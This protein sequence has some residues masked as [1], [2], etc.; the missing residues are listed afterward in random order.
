VVKHALF[1]L[2]LLAAL[3]A[4]APAAPAAAQSAER[5][6]PETGQ[7]IAGPIRAY[8]ERNGGLERFG[9]P[10][11]PQ[12]VETVEG[13]TIQVQW[14]ERDR[15]EIQADGL[16]TAGR[17]GVQRLEQLGIQWQQLP[18][19]NAIIPGCRFFRETQLNVCG[20]FLAY[21]E[22]NGGLER[23]GY[24][25]TRERT[26][27]LEGREY[28]VQYFERRRME[29]HPENAGTPYAVLLGLLGREVLG[30]GQGAAIPP[31][32]ENINPNLRAVYARV[33]L[34]RPLGCPTLV[35]GENVPAAIQTMERG[36]MIWY[37]RAEGPP[38][39]VLGPRIF[40][41]IAPNNTLSFR[42]Y[43][44]TWVEG[45]DPDVPAGSPPRPDLFAPWRGF[46]KVWAADADLRAQ[47]GWAR[48]S[49][50][51]ADRADY[52]LFDSG[53]LLVHLREA[54]ITYAFG[55]PGS[56]SEVQAFVR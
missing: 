40:A 27:V 11:T 47:I 12:R 50:A 23:F 39:L 51:R 48:E 21:W 44:D 4:L 33:Q 31:C 38:M 14:F 15:L 34:G 55:S 7:C 42:T 32:A 19:D 30:P 20:A 2:T 16:V 46:G 9:Y 5:C 25:V 52:Q 29:Y 41:V 28:T 54:G 36:Q 24:P 17:L 3:A 37:G 43:D 13:R 45:Q 1:L 26:E 35:P 56:P 22:R 6:F 18:G 53:I 10:I 8:W 49:Q